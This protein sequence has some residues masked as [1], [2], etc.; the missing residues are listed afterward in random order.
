MCEVEVVETYASREDEI[1]CRN[2]EFHELPRELANFR[3]YVNPLI[4]WV[5][6]GTIVLGIGT[7]ICIIM[8]FVY[9]LIS[10]RP[11][12]GQVGSL[13]RSV[14]IVLVTCATQSTSRWRAAA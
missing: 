13:G 6:I 5:W 2:P 11:G 9:R 8:G 3:V 7:L 12:R 4:T 1:G 10:A 14:A